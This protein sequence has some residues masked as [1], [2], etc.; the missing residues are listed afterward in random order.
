MLQA[1]SGELFGSLLQDHILYNSPVSLFAAFL[2]LVICYIFSFCGR[3]SFIHSG[4]WLWSFF[5]VIWDLVGVLGKDLHLI[6]ETARNTANL[7]STE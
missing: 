2:L 7:A 4:P 1:P 5:H 6:L 3:S